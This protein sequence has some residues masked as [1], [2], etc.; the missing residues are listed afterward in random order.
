VE[1]FI[2][3]PRF[4]LAIQ[5]ENET[6]QTTEGMLSE[7]IDTLRKEVSSPCRW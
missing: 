6:A 7:Q 5:K 1:Q 2:A 4:G 3:L